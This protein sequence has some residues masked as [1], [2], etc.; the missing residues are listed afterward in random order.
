M[1]IYVSKEQ[2]DQACSVDLY[3]F[4]LRYHS[5]AVKQKYGSLL[6]RSDDHVSV[7]R[8]F[9]GYRNFKTNETGN[10][11]DYLMRYLDYGYQDAVLALTGDS[12]SDCA[13]ASSFPVNNPVIPEPK[14]I[15]LPRPLEG[16]YCNLYAFLSKRK[17]PADI[18]QRL[19]HD[20]IM[21]QSAEGNNIVFVSPQGDYCELRGTNTYADRRCRRRE[22]CVRYQVGEHSWCRLMNNC[23]DYKSDPFHGCRK[24]QPDRFWFFAPANEPSEVVYVCEAAIDAVS[25]YCLHRE[26]NVTIPA[27][28]VSIGGAAN[29]KAIDRLRKHKNVVIATDNDDAGN[30]CRM[31]NADLQTI[32]PVFKDWN[33]DLQKGVYYGDRL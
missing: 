26:H 15:K 10:N 29:Q 1:G 18:I 22:D 5:N 9:H 11:V 23:P 2:Y 33:E 16:R 14:E 21:Y 19:I 3:D 8:G 28:Y 24:T 12:V 20:G 6:L 7:G 17:I 13:S 4:L 32:V 30:A 27:V 31:R 25:L